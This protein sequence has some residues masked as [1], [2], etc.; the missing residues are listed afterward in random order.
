MKRRVD[1]G[2]VLAVLIAVHLVWG[3]ARI[4]GKVYGKRLQH[5]ADYEREGA[6]GY[7]MDRRFDSHHGG[8]DAVRWLL[9]NTARD[10]VVLWEGEYKGAFELASG[11]LAPRLLV[12]ADRVP[13][14][15]DSFLGRPLAR[16]RSGVA[17]LVGRGDDVELRFR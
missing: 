13:T 12:R 6:P 5:V 3:A 7:L 9:E 4:P 1:I 17:V 11:L 15:S 14:D 10:A 16:S 8:A 2:F